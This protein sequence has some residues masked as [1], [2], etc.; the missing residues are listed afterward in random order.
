MCCIPNKLD[1]TCSFQKMC[2]KSVVKKVL[3]FPYVEWRLRRIETENLVFCVSV[4]YC[5]G[6]Y[7]FFLLYEMRLF[8]FVHGRQFVL[9]I[10]THY[11]QTSWCW[12]V[13]SLEISRFFQM[14]SLKKCCI[15]VILSCNVGR[16]EAMSVNSSYMAA[17]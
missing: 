11:E 4:I 3:F 5:L 7:I 16:I 9:F 17:H 12:L 8:F 1:V 10:I 2:L 13:M 15:T 14:R 6:L